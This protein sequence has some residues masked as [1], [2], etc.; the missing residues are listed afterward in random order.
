MIYSSTQ[1]L[2]NHFLLK[3][4]ENPLL[5]EDIISVLFLIQNSTILFDIFSYLIFFN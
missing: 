1:Y 2:L 5:R 3:M 4:N